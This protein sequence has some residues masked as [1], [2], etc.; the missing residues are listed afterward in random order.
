M[1]A[2]MGWV[3]VTGA[4]RGIGKAIAQTLACDGFD[5]VLW[6]RSPAE[7]AETAD[8]VTALGSR[9]QVAKV[10]VSDP[11]QVAAAAKSLSTADG[12]AGLVLNAG[13]GRW[14]PLEDLDLNSWDQTVRTNL[15]GCYHVLRAVLPSLL[16][17]PPSLLVGLLSDSAYYP[18]AGRA[19]YSAS[20]AGMR[21]LLEVMRREVRGRGIRVSLVA[22]SRV[23]THFVGSHPQARPGTRPGALSAEDVGQIVG[24][25]FRLP[26]HIEIREIQVS[27]MTATFG[28]YPERSGAA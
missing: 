5:L 14:A 19:A 1:T 8:V 10:D 6:A 13:K 3:L 20:K 12:L 18:F 2:R 21:A 24:T 4:S 11:G 25:L 16:A 28:P 15:D 9:V 22:P 7:L 27:S 26:S 17:D 23:D